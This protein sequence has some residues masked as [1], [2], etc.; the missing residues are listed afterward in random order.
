[1]PILG[2]IASSTRQGLVTDTGAVYPLQVITVSGSG[3]TSVSFTNIPSTYKHLQVRAITLNTGN[4]SIQ[5]RFN[6]DST[7]LYTRHFLSGDGSTVTSFG[8]AS[9]NNIGTLFASSST[10]NFFQA[11]I[12]DLYDYADT[13]KFKTC[14]SF[15]GVD[16]NSAGYVAIVSGL[17]RST[18]AISQ[19]NLIAA[20]GSF[21]QY[22]QFAL[23]GVKGA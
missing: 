7:A 19:I 21:N 18:N 3:A 5:T 11:T 16:N 8:Q 4:V 12:M 14:R 23:Y 1:M 2:T 9:I 17:Y 20:G 15:S 10:A 22:S 13:N 6:N